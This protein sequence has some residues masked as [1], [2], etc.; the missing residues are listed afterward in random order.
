MDTNLDFQSVGYRGHISCDI[1]KSEMVGQ[2]LVFKYLKQQYQE[3]MYSLEFWM[4][5]VVPSSF[6]NSCM[7]PPD[8]FV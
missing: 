1:E 4:M 3:A 2:G 6:C 8:F 7:W 5:E